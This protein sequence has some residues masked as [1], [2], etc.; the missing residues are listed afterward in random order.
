MKIWKLVIPVLIAA[1][2]LVIAPQASWAGEK[3]VTD[4]TGRTVTVPDRAER[5]VVLHEPLLGVPI[6]DIGGTVVGAYGRTDDGKVLTAVNFVTAVL[7]PDAPQPKSG[8]G[9]IGT[10]DL[11]RLRALH[12]DLIISTEHDRD[13]A[14]QLSAVAPV[15]LQASSTGEVYGFS[16]QADLARLIGREG[17]FETRLAEYRARLDEVRAVLP[18]SPQAK[19]YLAIMVSDQ[20]SL[21]GN[22]SGLVQAVEDLGYTRAP[23]GEAGAA[24]GLGSTFAVPL[25]SEILGRLDPDLLIVMK[26][27]AE[28]DRDETAIRQRLDR[29]M[30]GWERFMKPAR[31]GRILF[32]DSAPVATPT[33]AS[34]E[35][36]LDTFEAWA[37]H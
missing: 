8:I 6:L 17:A 37:R 3:T 27:Y 24:S 11:E 4:D 30:P 18:E 35:N 16:S 28:A 25:S 23:L 21:V 31:E 29:I 20:V 36:F 13:K 15:Y 1:Q 12:P 19:T 22:M 14:D 9:A 33:V 2:A 34:A 10:I 26:S 32:L 5:I 7:G